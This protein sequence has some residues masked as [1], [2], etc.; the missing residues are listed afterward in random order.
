[1][2]RWVISR[3]NVKVTSSKW[4]SRSSNFNF[5][6]TNLLFLRLF[7]CSFL[8]ASQSALTRVNAL[9]WYL[10]WL[11][12][13]RAD[14]LH[15]QPLLFLWQGKFRL[16]YSLFNV[17]QP[18]FSITNMTVNNSKLLLLFRPSGSWVDQNRPIHTDVYRTRWVEVYVTERAQ[19]QVVHVSS[20]S[21]GDGYH[22]ECGRG[23]EGEWTW[24]KFV[25]SGKGSSMP[26]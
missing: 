22:P 7:P 6:I 15:T 20:G 4:I 16:V 10:V 26:I 3:T 14:A 25:P 8:S 5:S 23:E 9:V 12:I 11:Q 19:V 18:D 17:P 13:L 2:V 24:M 21:G 1:M